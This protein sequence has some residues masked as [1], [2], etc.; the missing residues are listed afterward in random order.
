MVFEIQI[1]SFELAKEEPLIVYYR[2]SGRVIALA[3]WTENEQISQD[4]VILS[5]SKRW[6]S[7]IHRKNEK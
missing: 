1:V 4:S 2:Q 7:P 6:L 3:A 5:E